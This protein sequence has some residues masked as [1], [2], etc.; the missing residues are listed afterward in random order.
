MEI[1]YANTGDESLHQRPKTAPEKAQL[2][3]NEL[4]GVFYSEAGFWA[5]QSEKRPLKNLPRAA[6]QDLHTF[7]RL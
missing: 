6:V 7:I 3:T 1:L 4:V 2:H 5:V